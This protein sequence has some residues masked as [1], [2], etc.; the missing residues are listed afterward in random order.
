MIM[1][2]PTMYT[3]TWKVR[4]NLFLNNIPSYIHELQLGS[5]ERASHSLKSLTRPRQ[6]T[7]MM[8]HPLV[9]T[10]LT[11]GTFRLQ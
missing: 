5:N 2:A 7:V 9:G 11:I 6:V 1:N 10:W 8:T 4:Y 3:H